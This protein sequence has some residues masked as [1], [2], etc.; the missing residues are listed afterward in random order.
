M[1][2][3]KGKG[4]TERTYNGGSCIPV[5]KS[6]CFATNWLSMKRVTTPFGKAGSVASKAVQVTAT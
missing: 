1:A 2:K 5:A 4:V 3:G 6:S